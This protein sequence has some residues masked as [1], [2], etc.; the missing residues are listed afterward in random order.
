LE[1]GAADDLAGGSVVIV[2]GETGSER[3][4]APTG[5]L[6]L[7][8]MFFCPGSGRDLYAASVSGAIS[9]IHVE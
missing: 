5:A 9:R 3:G 6:F 1:D 7:G 2:D 4:R 8:G